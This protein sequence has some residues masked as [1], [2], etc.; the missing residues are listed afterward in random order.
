[1]NPAHRGNWYRRVKVVVCLP[2]SSAAEIS[3]TAMS[4]SGTSR[5][6]S[7]DLPMPDWPIRIDDWPASSGEGGHGFVRPRRPTL[8]APDSRARHTA[9][10]A[11]APASERDHV[12][13]VEDQVGLDA[14][15]LGRHQRARDQVV[16]EARFGGDHDEQLGQV[17]RQQLGLVL[18]RAVQQGLAFGDLFDHGLVVRGH[19]Q[20]T[21]SPTATLVFLPRVTHCSLRRRR[22]PGSGGR[23]RR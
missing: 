20:V 14:G 3:R 21:M 15:R 8:R 1:M 4:A 19:L 5:L 11:R 12:G 18:V 22:R 16:G 7:E 2:V 13:L 10:G 9:A 17:G 6:I 23:G